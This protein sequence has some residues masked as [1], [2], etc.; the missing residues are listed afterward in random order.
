MNCHDVDRALSQ[1][2]PLPL[3]A[4][5][6]AGTC[7]RC[8]QLLAALNQSVPVD[9]LSPAAL[10]KIAESLADNLRPVRPMAPARYFVGAFVG[11][12]VSIV[13]FS[14][15]RLGAFAIPVMTP[16]QTTTILSTLAIGTGLLVYSLVN[17]MVPGS[18]HRIPPAPLAV[19]ITILVAMV[20]AVLFQV[21]QEENFWGNAWGCIRAGTLVGALAAVPFWLVLRRGAILSPRMTGAAA[22]LLAGLA[23]TSMLE[24][25]CPI[26]DAW[27]ILLSHLGVAILCALAGLAIALTAEI[28]ER[29]SMHRSSP[30]RGAL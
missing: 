13:A 14:V 7:E 27:H 26:L 5:E 23:G 12:F 24:M 3:Q 25:H 20:M 10:R 11:I 19:G 2:S 22:G 6:H 18:R 17:Q 4:E 1:G 8:Q 15:Y 28:R 16:L 30:E 9:P 29:R 21:Q